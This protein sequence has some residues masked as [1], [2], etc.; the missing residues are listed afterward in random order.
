MR[1]PGLPRL[2][3]VKEDDSW[4][5]VCHKTLT[6]A[7]VLFAGWAYFHT[8]HPVFTKEKELLEARG[9]LQGLFRQRDTL[10]IELRSQRARVEQSTTE[11]RAKQDQLQA[12][13][14]TFDSIKQQVG[15]LQTKAG[16]L[17]S[18]V[19]RERREAS[20]AY[21]LRVV[22]TIAREAIDAQVRGDGGKGFDLQARCLQVARDGLAETGKSEAERRG[23]QVLSLFARRQLKPGV[24]D[25]RGLFDIYVFM[26][27]DPEAIA[28][29]RGSHDQ[30]EKP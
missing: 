12:M 15:E 25:F 7:G 11:I 18:A 22:D 26:V 19:E 14:A 28:I 6:I 23:L 16:A 24:R 21:A 20:R 5:E 17:Q 27:A 13:T 29:M 3:F 30:S 10:E 8:V 2:R 1:L 9:E 4:L